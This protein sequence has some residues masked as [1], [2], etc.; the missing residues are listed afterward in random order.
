MENST[1]LF[2]QKYKRIV[3]IPSMQHSLN[4][5]GE[6]I[7]IIGCS[8]TGKST[9]AKRFSDKLGIPV[10]HLDKLA[11][12]SNTAWLRKPDKD[13]AVKHSQIVKEEKWIIEGNYSMCMQERIKHASSII[14]LDFNVFISAL[15]YL[16]RS[17][18][19]DSSRIGRLPGAKSELHWFML[20]QILSVY[21]KNRLEYQKLLKN[22]SKLIISIRNMKEL[23]QYCQYW[24]L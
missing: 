14:W 4:D 5:L 3:M 15:R 22:E 23:K 8:S 2:S 6:R 1:G 9:L 13:F 19:K 24:N 21:P 7:C 20:K 10:Y 17:F 18:K 12:Y 11:H 16:I